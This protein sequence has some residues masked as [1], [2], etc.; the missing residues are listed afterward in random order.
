MSDPLK[1][2]AQAGSRWP[3]PRPRY[4][5]YTYVGLFSRCRRRGAAEVGGGW[6]EVGG[7]RR[8]SE[9]VVLVCTGVRVP[10]RS[11]AERS[12]ASWRRQQSEALRPGV[13]SSAKR[14][15]LASAAPR[16]SAA[17]QSVGLGVGSTAAARSAGGPSAA[18]ARGPGRARAAASA[19]PFRRTKRR[20]GRL[21]GLAPARGG[22]ASEA[23]PA[24]GRPA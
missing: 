11:V 2:S 22:T 10:V 9:S 7:W 8:V 13:G 20:L 15:V 16:A 5:C 24:G 21:C 1:N 23:G 18:S 17:E 3:S 4:T 19:E 14:C 6:Q 12:V